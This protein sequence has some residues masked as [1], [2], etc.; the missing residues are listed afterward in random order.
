MDNNKYI[1]P[2]IKWVGGKTQI[3]DNIFNKF[4]LKINSY[5]ELFV[6]GGSVFIELLKRLEEKK[7]ILTKNITINDKNQ[8]LI[9]LYKIIK[10]NP[11]LLINQLEYFKEYF[12]EAEEINYEL[13]HKPNLTNNIDE[14]KKKGRLYLFYYYRDLYNKTNDE[15]IKS[16]LFIILNKTCYRGLYREGPNG[17]NVP[18]GHNKNPTIYIKEHL[19]FLS[20]M[21]NK[22]NV[23]FISKSFEEIENNF[24]SKDVIYI[25]PPYYPL[26]KTSFIAYKKGGFDNHAEL[27]TYIK[28]INKNAFFIHSNSYCDYNIKNYCDYKQEKILCKRLINSKNPKDKDYEIIIYN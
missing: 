13:R 9:N 26:E 10:T 5:Y 23:N 7:I 14:M 17:F 18:Y 24:E 22:Y 6:G 2:F 1:K 4:P 21:F 3:I 16:S 28:N 11:N 27:N 15:I 20:K 12:M 8:D 19:L 25:D